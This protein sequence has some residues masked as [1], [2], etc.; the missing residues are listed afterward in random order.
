[1]SFICWESRC[2][3]LVVEWW[4]KRNK[5]ILKSKNCK[6]R[7][8]LR[9]FVMIMRNEANKLTQRDIADYY[10]S[11]IPKLFYLQALWIMSTY[12]YLLHLF[13][14]LSISDSYLLDIYLSISDSYWPQ[15]RWILL[16]NPRDEVET[17]ANNCGNII[18]NNFFLEQLLRCFWFLL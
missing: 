14:Y 10:C 16:N 8:A 15:A 11:V 6:T 13:I 4:L 2:D 18:A 17:E 7:R 12:P 5:T 1:M 9:D 3:C